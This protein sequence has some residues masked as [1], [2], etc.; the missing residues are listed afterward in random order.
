M[1]CVQIIKLLEDSAKEVRDAAV[2]TL[3]KFY[4]RIGPSL[5]VRRASGWSDGVLNPVFMAF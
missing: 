5:L 1:D 4:S 3:E 2:E